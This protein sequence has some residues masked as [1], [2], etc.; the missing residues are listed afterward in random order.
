MGS[1]T[2]FPPSL[3]PR[4]HAVNK[5]SAVHT[6]VSLSLCYRLCTSAVRHHWRAS[7]QE[8]TTSHSLS[9][10]LSLSLSHF[11]ALNTSRA[12]AQS[13]SFILSSLFLCKCW[14]VTVVESRQSISASLGAQRGN[15]A[16]AVPAGQSACSHAGAAEK[17]DRSNQTQGKVKV[18]L[19]RHLNP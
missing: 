3:R 13:V 1:A 6:S 12:V 17:E 16:H 7:E 10:S 2:P 15:K 8:Q 18:T 11:T 14:T 9:P 5:C 4:S 19:R